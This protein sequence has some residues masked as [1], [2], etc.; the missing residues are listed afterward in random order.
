MPLDAVVPRVPPAVLGLVGHFE[1][2]NRL[3]ERRR[4]FTHANVFEEDIHVIGR[5]DRWLLLVT[6]IIP[7]GPAA[8]LPLDV[9]AAAALA[10]EVA[11]DEGSVLVELQPREGLERAAGQGQEL[12][13]RKDGWAPLVARVCAARE[14]TGVS[15]R[16]LREQRR[17]ALRFD[18]S[19]AAHS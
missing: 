6:Q 4:V 15:E 9:G 17:E 7:V 1:P 5:V 11:G 2:D 16:A 10:A 18:S 14:G 3:D 19:R 13:S 8:V 12:G